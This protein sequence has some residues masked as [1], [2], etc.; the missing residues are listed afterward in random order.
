[1]N[2][3][4]RSYF[5]ILRYRSPSIVSKYIYFGNNTNLIINTD[6]CSNMN[7]KRLFSSMIPDVI[8]SSINSL[9]N[10]YNIPWW[11]TFGLSTVFMRISLFPLVRYQIIASKKLSNAIP[12]I[13]FLI[14]L[15]QKRMKN[16]NMKLSERMNTIFTL[17]KGISAC[18]YLHE[19]SMLEIIAYPVANL[20]VF[21]TFIYSIKDMIVN[22]KHDDMLTGGVFWFIDLTVKDETFILPMLAIAVSY[23]SL[24]VGFLKNHGKFLLLFKDLLQS[25]LLVSIPFIYLLPSGVFFYWIPS[26]ICGIIQNNLVRNINFQRIF[27][28]PITNNPSINIVNNTKPLK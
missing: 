27:K 23:Y 22:S 2:I 6:R 13:R 4:R 26:S 15:F 17:Q 3:F 1:M 24:D 18:L 9:H 7:K 16:P 20:S 5:K 12:E 10:I 8:Q 14:Q 28:L 19:V 11:L 21:M 25:S